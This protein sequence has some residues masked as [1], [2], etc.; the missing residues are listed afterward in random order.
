MQNNGLNGLTTP[1]PSTITLV[2]QGGFSPTFAADFNPQAANM[3]AASQCENASDPYLGAFGAASSILDRLQEYYTVA[4]SSNGLPSTASAAN[5][6]LIGHAGMA[7]GE[8]NLSFE[9]NDYGN[10]QTLELT[11]KVTPLVST[12][13]ANSLAVLRG[14]WWEAQCL[15]AQGLTGSCPQQ[16]LPTIS[17][18]IQ[19]QA[20]NDNLP[21]ENCW[22]IFQSPIPQ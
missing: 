15:V 2:V 18:G 20:C 9:T 11:G 4:N 1:F 21:N 6:A 10:L 7:A 14:P 12:N 16:Y 19:P 5:T 8:I 13:E 17:E 3:A 22:T